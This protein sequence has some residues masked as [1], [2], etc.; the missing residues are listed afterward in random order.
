M[1]TMT[2]QKTTAPATRVRGGS[3]F[4]DRVLKAYVWLIIAWLFL[5][6]AVMIVFG[7]NDTQSKSNVTWQGFTFK[8]WGLLGDYPE[9]TLAV[10]NSLKIAV[11]STVITTV[12]GTLMGLALG[13]YRF[14]GQ[15]ATNLV[16]FAAIASPE[17]V[18]GASLLSLF[19]S[20]GVQTGFVTVVV[21]HVLFSLSFVAI[22]VR[23]R[24]IGLDPSIEEA[25]RDLGASTWVTFWR[26]TFP[27]ILP[28]VVAGALLAFA[29]SIDDFVI[30][31][32]TSGATQTFPLWIWGATRIGVPPQV[33]I[34]GTLIFA[35]GVA[36]AV[37][38]TVI[39]RRRT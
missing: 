19:I 10:E 16:M 25:A 20:S 34:I 32:F 27:M 36:I 2:S 24:V 12:I 29:L 39:S 21:A 13:R 5:P 22:T 17:L 38:N 14:R 23:A 35:I 26:V 28:G 15:G 4:G 11:L 8:W 33:N 30:T 3:R 37:F 18:M 31:Q 1:S 6:I 9:L 7:F